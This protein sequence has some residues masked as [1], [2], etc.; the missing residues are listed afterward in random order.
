[1]KMKNN[2]QLGKK[3]VVGLGE[4]EKKRK[5]EREDRGGRLEDGLFVMNEWI[6][7]I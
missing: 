1:M 2:I 5:G 4:C 7:E 6:D 3:T